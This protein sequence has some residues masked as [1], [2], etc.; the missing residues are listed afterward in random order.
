MSDQPINSETR[1]ALQ[2]RDIDD[3]RREV[4]EGFKQ[5]HDLQRLTNGRLLKAENNITELEKVN[6]Q[7][8]VERKYEKLVWWL[9]TSAIALVVGLA[10]YIIYN[11]A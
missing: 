1:E 3:L 7:R 2:K 10:S 5:T 8:A 11:H 6:I 9:C 4:V